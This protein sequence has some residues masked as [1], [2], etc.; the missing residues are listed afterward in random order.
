MGVAFRLEQIKKI[1]GPNPILHVHGKG[2]MEYTPVQESAYYDRKKVC[3]GSLARTNCELSA[4]TKLSPT[5]F[6]SLIP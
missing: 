3:Q 4:S 5:L 6:A 1:E 2:C